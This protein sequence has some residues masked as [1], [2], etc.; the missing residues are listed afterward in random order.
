MRIL[1]SVYIVIGRRPMVHVT[2]RIVQ[3]DDGWAYTVNGAFSQPFAT[4]A[5]AFAAARTAAAEQRC[6]ATQRSS[7]TRTK[8]PLA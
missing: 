4:H 2:Y 1:G 5:E 6:P 3:H 8:G 7:N